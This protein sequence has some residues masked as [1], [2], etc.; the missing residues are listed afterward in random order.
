MATFDIVIIPLVP[1]V[2]IELT[3]VFAGIPVPL[4][5]APTTRST[6]LISVMVVDPVVNF[7][8]IT[9]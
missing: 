5:V 3:V 4:T 6:V 1:I 7:P 2:S 8:C 9:N